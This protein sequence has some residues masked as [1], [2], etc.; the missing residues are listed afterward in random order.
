MATDTQLELDAASPEVKRYQRQKITV[1]LISASLS[2]GWMAVLGIFLGGQLGELYPNE[3]WQRLLASAGMLAVTLEIL[4]FPLDFFSGFVLE[5]R[6]QLSNQTRAGWARKR[7]KGYLVAG[8]LG[9]GLVSGLYGALW[10]F[11]IGRAHV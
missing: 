4:T 6:Y 10:V 5:H 11:E 7:I 1:L 3:P 2:L 9:L 8:V